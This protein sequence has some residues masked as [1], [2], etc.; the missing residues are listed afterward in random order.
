MRRQRYGAGQPAGGIPGLGGTYFTLGWSGGSL[1]QMTAGP[2]CVAMAAVMFGGW[3]TGR[4]TVAALIIGLATSLAT[5]PSRLDVN[6]NPNLLLGA[7]L[8][9]HH[10]GGGQRSARRRLWGGL[11]DGNE[12]ALCDPG[13]RRMPQPDVAIRY[14]GEVRQALRDRAPVVAL[15]S[16][17]I[18]HGLPRP[19]NLE[20]AEE[21]ECI[22]RD[23]GACPA[24]IAVLDGIPRIGLRSGELG[25]I[26]SDEPLRKLGLR[27]LPMA[28]ATGASGGTTVSA[29][30]FLATRAGLRV[31]ATG[32]IGG[33]HRGWH[34]TWDESADLLALSRTRITVV[35]SGVKSILDIP[36]TLQRLE[37]LSITVVGYQT[38]TFPGFYLRS[39]GNPVD[40]RADSPADVAAIM[41]R[42]DALR[43]T[44]GAIL[45][46]NPVPAGSELDPGLH[47]RVLAEALHAAD[48]DGV[49]GQELTPYLL[50]Q[51]LEGTRGRSL[52]ANLAAVQSN[53][54]LAARIANEWNAFRPK[55]A[56]R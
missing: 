19:R 33:V 47:D 1:A 35:A 37:T 51:M 30:A 13:M 55:G 6:V 34:E 44:R 14:S 4:A 20:V 49:R 32:G 15:E 38:D 54:R 11:A 2:G 56:A 21:L 5:S 42:Q 24:T 45:V 26:A 9:G 52:E 28:A 36:A 22:V 31:F 39:S 53:A 16:T 29:T 50:G 12:A 27:D 40:W 43:M 17:I 41:D 8:L 46:A 10:R 25:R 7:A 23:N 48:R 3:P 18:S